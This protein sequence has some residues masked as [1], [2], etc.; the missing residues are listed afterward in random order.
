MRFN[1]PILSTFKLAIACFTPLLTFASCATKKTQP[2][3]SPATRLVWP[4]APEPPRIVYAQ[5]IQQPSDLGAKTS[6]FNRFAN[7]IIG[8]DKGRE[9]L[10]KPFG[11]SLD[12][13]DNLCVTDTGANAV[14]FF[15]QA[16]KK[17]TRWNRIEKVRFRSPVAVAK[18]NNIFFVADSSLAA[19]VAFGENG[20][21]VFQATNHLERPSGLVISGE[22]LFVADSQRH[23]IVVFD[24]RGKYIS[25]FGQRGTK[26]GEFNF[27]THIA[28][29]AEGNLFVTDSMNCR[30]QMLD[31]A[32]QF[33]S[34]IGSIGNATGHFSR[35]KGVAVDSFGHVYVIDALFDNIQIFDDQGKLLLNWGES[36]GNPGEFWLPNGIAITK[37]NTIYVADSYNRRIQIFKYVGER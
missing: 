29:D 11:V 26:P 8:A 16:K 28:A 31:H 9:Q 13:S 30:V 18:R 35:P 7:W 14:C 10:L 21:L 2:T 23:R 4:A 5:S 3:A 19:I 25:E 37:H 33:K 6:G 24:L 27:P 1:S 12:E 32:G 20:K 36:G 17:W 15:D 34:E 22:Q